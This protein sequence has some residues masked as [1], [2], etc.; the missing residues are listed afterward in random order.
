M[1][2]RA[3]DGNAIRTRLAQ[4][5]V[6]GGG[7][8]YPLPERPSTADPVVLSV[9]IGCSFGAT[10]NAVAI[11]HLNRE[12]KVAIDFGEHGFLCTP[13][14]T[15]QIPIGYLT[16]AGEYQFLVYEGSPDFDQQFYL[17]T[18]DLTV[19]PGNMFAAIE[20]P[21]EGSIQSGVG[22]IRGWA[23]DAKTISISIDDG[24]LIPVAYG[25]SRED[26]RKRCGD[27]NNGYGMVMAWGLLPLGTHTLKTFH[28]NREIGHVTFTVAGIGGSGFTK[29]LSGSYDLEGFPTPGDRV[30]VQWSE[31]DQ[32]FIIID[33][34]SG[35]S[36]Q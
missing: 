26:T 16:D 15:T 33:K 5:K 3:G 28:D 1:A 9:T 20:T 27:A 10:A 32:N 2:Q 6:S 36:G 8:I 13:E 25:S 11:D 29:G 14:I 21:A 7:D 17:G 30:T 23:C 18:F 12:V 35:V 4:L 24:P 22:V 34:Q 19:L 31:P